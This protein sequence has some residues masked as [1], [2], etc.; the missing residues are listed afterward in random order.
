MNSS[1]QV[2]VMCLG[3]FIL[4]FSLGYLPTKMAAPTKIMN[5][6][7]IYGA[8]LLVGS[9]LIVII[10]EGMSVLYSS[11]TA[12]PSQ[13]GLLSIPEDDLSRASLSALV[14]ARLA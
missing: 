12:A 7:S 2:V 3:M 10:P 5:L 1:T 9:A 11:L 14:D 4:T 8:G 6:I 13:I